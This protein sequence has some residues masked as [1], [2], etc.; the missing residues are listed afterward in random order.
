MT[1]PL[2]LTSGQVAD[3]IGYTSAGAFMR[4]RARLEAD[5][6][7]PLPM[8]THRHRAMRWRADEV[9]AWVARNGRPRPASGANLHLLH[10]AASA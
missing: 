7:F 2:F 5:C 1:A 9:Q 4:D 3:A 6:L 8:P 10:L